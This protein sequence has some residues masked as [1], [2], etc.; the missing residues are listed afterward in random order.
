M[1]QRTRYFLIGSAFVVVIGLCTGLVAYYGGDLSRSRAAAPEFSYLPPDATAVAYAD[2][3]DIMKSG[4]SQKLRQLLPT[5]AE[6]ERLAAELGVDLERDID[7]MASAFSGP[8][9]GIVILRGR[10]DA[11]KIE[12]AALQHGDVVGEYHGKRLITSSGDVTSAPG[13]APNPMMGPFAFSNSGVAFL[14]TNLIAIGPVPALQHAIDTGASR[15][16]ITDNPEFMRFVDEARQSGNAWIVARVDGATPPQGMPDQLKEQLPKIKFFAV[17]ADVDQ[18]LTGSVRV[19]AVDAAAGEDLRKVVSGTIAAAKLFGGSNPT[20]AT[21]LNA[22]QVTGQ[23]AD[24]RL[25]FVLTA[26]TLEQLSPNMPGPPGR[27]ATG[28]GAG[29]GPEAMP[30]PLPR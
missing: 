11:K 26:E 8:N 9:S 2:V 16:D 23:G 14:E 27:G 18:T 13:P 6:K 28:R 7:S 3:Q 5:G 20:L 10:F 24:A 12:A 1:N 17:S 19:Q 22:M 4:F 25:T 30:L 15:Q 21:A 29:R